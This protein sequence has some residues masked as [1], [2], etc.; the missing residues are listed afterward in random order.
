MHTL[1]AALPPPL[2]PHCLALATNKKRSRLHRQP[3]Q[4]QMPCRTASR[5][6]LTRGPSTLPCRCRCRNGKVRRRRY[7]CPP[8]CAESRIDALRCVAGRRGIGLGKRRARSPTPAERLAKMAKMAES[9][10]QRDFRERA[11][12]EYNNRRAEGRLGACPRSSSKH[13][14]LT[15]CIISIVCSA[16]AEYVYDTRRTRG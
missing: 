4:M 7:S 3:M 2:Y 13:A 12:D 16:C 11:R 5:R 6:A 8:A 1:A 9:S 14:S 10:G 15:G